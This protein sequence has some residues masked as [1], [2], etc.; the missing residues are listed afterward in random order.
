ME[1]IG[2]LNSVMMILVCPFCILKGMLVKES[3]NRDAYSIIK[4]M[5]TGKQNVSSWSYPYLY[6]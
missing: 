1:M 4:G 5:T 3:S 6:K 2:C